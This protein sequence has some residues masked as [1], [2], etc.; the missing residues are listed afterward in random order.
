MNRLHQWLCRSD[1]W[2]STVA[3]RLPWALGDTDLGSNVL[4]IG[5]GPGLTTDLL[6]T[7]VPQLTSLEIDAA[8]A[9]SLSSRLKGSNV[10]VIEGDATKMPFVE[11]EFSGAV[12]FTMLHHVPSRELQNK[13][14]AEVLRVLKPGG[15]FV[16]SDSL[17]NWFMKIIHIGDTLVPVNPDTF[18]VRLQSAGF[19][20]LEVRR[21][22]QAFRFRARR[23]TASPA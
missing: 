2:R 7:M 19:E 20:V 18:G 12:S 8:L 6:R 21:N 11:S 4:E 5:P 10:Q 22:S 13:V 17:Q 23:P 1:L 9:S 3:Q 16:G 15:F 14:L